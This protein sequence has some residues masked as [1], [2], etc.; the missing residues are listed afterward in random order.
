MPSTD[1]R[2]L[3]VLPHPGQTRHGPY[4]PVMA[5][6]HRHGL[7]NWH[8]AGSRDTMWAKPQG[9]PVSAGV[10]GGQAFGFALVVHLHELAVAGRHFTPTGSQAGWCNGLNDNVEAN[11]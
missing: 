10:G 11:T 6:T 2:L 7:A 3:N 9:D 4:N 1:G 5:R 8:V